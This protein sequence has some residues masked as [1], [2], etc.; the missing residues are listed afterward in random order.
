MVVGS[1]NGI[2]VYIYMHSHKHTHAHTHT[3][4]RAHKHTH[5]HTQTHTHMHTHTHALT[6]TYISLNI[7]RR[8]GRW[9]SIRYNPED[10]NRM[11]KYRSLLQK[12]PTKETYILQ[13][14]IY[15]EAS[16]SS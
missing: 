13:R 7:Y 8:P 11:Y 2:Y 16:Y 5:T 9:H 1:V 14:D 15:F 6:Q 4:T 10:G 3:H 12:R